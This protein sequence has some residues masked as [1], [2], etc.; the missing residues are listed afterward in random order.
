MI[1]AAAVAGPANA[2]FCGDPWFITL[3]G[4]EPIVRP[5]SDGYNPER[6]G[7]QLF[8]RFE[9]ALF[10]DDRIIIIGTF[11]RTSDDPF[12]HEAFAEELDPL[13]PE[14]TRVVP[15]TSEFYYHDAYTFDGYGVGDGRLVSISARSVD[16]VYSLREG[17]AQGGLPLEGERYLLAVESFDGYELVMRPF[18]CPDY[19]V[20]PPDEAALGVFLQCIVDRGC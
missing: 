17:S 1:V 12:F 6:F 7:Q 8:E 2:T 9:S 18:W 16:I 20:T 4:E 10:S 3:P 11:K 5:G 15:I 14:N 19:L 13:N